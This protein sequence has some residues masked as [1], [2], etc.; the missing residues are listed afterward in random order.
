VFKFQ[1]KLQNT[2]KLELEA[3]R[4]QRKYQFIGFLFLSLTPNRE[5]ASKP[6]CQNSKIRNESK[7]CASI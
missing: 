4:A 2:T 7:N 3:T 5:N 1:A 6:K